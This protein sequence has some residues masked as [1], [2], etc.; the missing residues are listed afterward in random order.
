MRKYKRR[1]FLIDKSFQLKY[2]VLLF[3]VLLFQS[4]IVMAATFVPQMVVMKFSANI[5]E[6]IA[7][8]QK[9]LLLHG[10][11]WPGII[12][13]MVLLSGFSIFITHKIAG[14]V[15]RIKKSLQEIIAGNL[16]EKIVLRKN[17]ELM[18]L[19][20]NVNFLTANMRDCLATIKESHCI[21]SEHLVE[22]ERQIEAGTISEAAGN[23]LL[24]KIRS[25]RKH[26][27]ELLNK[28]DT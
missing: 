6:K 2:V 17:D 28:F 20:E 9:F 1:I 8:S 11:I 18:D 27:E 19:A 15:Y 14:P 16:N 24:I 5:E 4:L 21:Q 7:A 26:M 25:N 12:L 13:S 3:T 22:L 10:M 23:D